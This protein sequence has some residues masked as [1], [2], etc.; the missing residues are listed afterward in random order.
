MAN[1]NEKQM[2]ALSVET[3]HPT[4][5]Q[6]AV[7]LNIDKLVAAD[8]QVAEQDVLN[9]PSEDM[10]KK[11][12]ERANL[13][14]AYEILVK[15]KVLEVD[16]DGVVSITEEGQS[17]VEEVKKTA[18]A[19]VPAGPEG[20]MPGEE[21]EGEPDLGLEGPEGEGMGGEEGPNLDMGE[22]PPME[23]FQLIRKLHELDKEQKILNGISRKYL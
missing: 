17:I 1:I 19:D 9:I 20:E 3:F 13:E 16:E 15:I 10:K 7:L 11:G 4:E 14:G 8:R 22:E 2:G 18:D 6:R 5:A 23:S 21:P 12:L